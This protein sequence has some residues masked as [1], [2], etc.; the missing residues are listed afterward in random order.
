MENKNGRR[1]RRN[2]KKDGRRDHSGAAGETADQN[3][4]M[5]RQMNERAEFHVM[6]QPLDGGEP[7]HYTASGLDYVYLLNG[8]TIEDDPDYGRMVSIHE[9]D[10]LHVAIGLYIISRRRPV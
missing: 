5:G 8:F 1:S 2:V 10:A 4:R 3:G 9:P 6:G 7:L